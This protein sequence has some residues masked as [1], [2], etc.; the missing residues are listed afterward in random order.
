MAR[1]D[2]VLVVVGHAAL[3]VLG[4]LLGLWGGFLVALRLPGGVEGVS[5]L[6]AVVGNL[7]AARLGGFGFGTPLAAATPGIGW[8]LAVMV[9]L[10]GL[11]GMSGHAQDVLIP[12]NLPADPGVVVVGY[13][14]VFGGA[15]AALAGILWVAHL[16]RPRTTPS[17]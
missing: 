2:D 11:P 8:L 15:G 12:G 9:L 14:W 13:A 3:F 17:A 5:V 4:A 10:G 16:V 1:D 7:A 6:I